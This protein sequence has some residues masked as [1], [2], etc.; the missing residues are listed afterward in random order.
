MYRKAAARA[1]MQKM[2]RRTHL[3]ASARVPLSPVA[4]PLP[5]PL[6]KI[7][8]S[9]RRSIMRSHRRITLEFRFDHLR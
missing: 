6:I 7:N 2:G 9:I 1:R 4:C 5:H 8:Q 3:Y